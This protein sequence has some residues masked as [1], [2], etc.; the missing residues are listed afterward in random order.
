MVVSELSRK[1][2]PCDSI[3]SIMGS[4]VRIPPISSRT[5]QT[6]RSIENLLPVGALGNN[7]H[8]LHRLQPIISVQRIWRAGERRWLVAH[9]L[10]MLVPGWNWWWWWQWCLLLLRPSLLVHFLPLLVF[11]LHLC[12]H[13]CYDVSHLLHYLHLGCNCGISSGWWGIWRIHLSLLLWLSK[14]PP[15]VS[16]G[17]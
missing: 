7:Q 15:T 4:S 11:L 9:E 8:L 2:H 14:Y 13:I 16:I 17:R 10:S 3:S 1:F 5:S 12:M 6:T